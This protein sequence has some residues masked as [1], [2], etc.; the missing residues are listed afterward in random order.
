MTTKGRRSRLAGML[1][2]SAVLLGGLAFLATGEPA[3]AADSS[4][5]LTVTAGE[6]TYE[7]SGAPKPGWVEVE[8]D[9]A[10]VEPT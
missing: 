9:N 1:A 10:G 2:V 3:G 4:N 8:F 7:F 5:K 6:Y